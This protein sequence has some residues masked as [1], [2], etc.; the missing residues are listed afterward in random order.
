MIDYDKKGAPV[1][2]TTVPQMR[3]IPICCRLDGPASCHLQT[4]PAQ[5]VLL[6]PHPFR[7]NAVQRDYLML[8]YDGCEKDVTKD[9]SRGVNAGLR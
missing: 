2:H 4:L 3:L 1:E 8:S 6:I 9:L 5:F 7:W